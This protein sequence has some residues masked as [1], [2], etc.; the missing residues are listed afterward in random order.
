M[1]RYPTVYSSWW[2]EHS[3]GL[4]YPREEAATFYGGGGLMS[5]GLSYQDLIKPCN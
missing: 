1:E 3:G 5:D 2:A 4:Q